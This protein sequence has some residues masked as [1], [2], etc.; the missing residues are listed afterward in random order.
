MIFGGNPRTDRATVGVCWLSDVTEMVRVAELPCSS[1]GRKEGET[2]SMKAPVEGTTKKSSMAVRGVEV[3]LEVNSTSYL[4]PS[5]ICDSVGT[6]KTAVNSPLVMSTGAGC[7][8][9][10]RNALVTGPNL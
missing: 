2:V 4:P 10:V 5:N 6:V 1:G 3:P 8:P 7:P 9:D